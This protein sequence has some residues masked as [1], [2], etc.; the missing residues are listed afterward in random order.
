MSGI[1]FGAIA[2]HGPIAVR[3]AC[4]D[5]ELELA[6]GTLTDSTSLRSAARQRPAEILLV[7]T[8]HS[9]HVDGALSV[10]VSARMEGAVAGTDGRTIMLDCEIDREL[11]ASRWTALLDAGVPSVGVSFGG[12]RLDEAVVPMDWGT[13]I[14]FWHLGGRSDPPLRAVVVGPARDLRRRRMSPRDARSPAPPGARASESAFVASADH[15]HAH[16]AEGPYG[17]DEAAAEYD[18]T[19]VAQI[20]DENRLDGL[21]SIEPAFVERAAADSWWQL[22]MLHGA[23]GDGWSPSSLV[24]GADVLRDALR[25]LHARPRPSQPGEQPRAKVVLE[26]RAA[27]R[28]Q[29]LLQRLADHLLL[30]QLAPCGLEI[31]GEHRDRLRR[32][33]HL[34]T[35]IGGEALSPASELLDL[36]VVHIRHLHR[37]RGR[38]NPAVHGNHAESVRKSKAAVVLVRRRDDGERLAGSALGAAG[39]SRLGER[40]RRS[41]SIAAQP[42]GR[43][44]ERAGAAVP[45]R[46][47]A[48]ARREAVIGPSAPHS[49]QLPTCG[50]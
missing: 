10:V 25:C 34:G 33:L 15:G 16:A 49:A 29:L 31:V 48:G 20:I 21:P 6:A 47:A 3:E 22:L 45:R 13:L 42:V 18:G 23:L 24:R 4:T 41:A 27:S 43:E 2:P 38:C 17:Y 44:G 50:R 5:D 28:R 35:G 36:P 9:V 37:Q 8:P 26:L 30:E 46:R 40:L 7:A 11:A 39:R 14:P 12:N 19:I 1:V 32:G